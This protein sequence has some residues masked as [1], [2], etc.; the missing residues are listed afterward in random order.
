MTLLS[1]RTV[2]HAG[3]AATLIPAAA[4]AGLDRAG[5]SEDVRVL[6]AA[7]EAMHPGLYSHAT[8]RQVAARFERLQAE[9]AGAGDLGGW[10]VALSRFTAAVRCGHTYPNPYNQSDAAAEALFGGRRCLPFLARWLDGRLVVTGD[11]TASGLFRPGDEVLS[12]GGI[13]TERWRARMLPLMRAD[14]GNDAKRLNNLELRG[15]DRFEAFDVYAS[16][17]QPTLRDEAVVEVRGRDGRRR[18]FSAPLLSRETKLARTAV[19]AAPDAA[20]WTLA[21]R[22]GGVAVLTMPTWAFYDGKW[23]WAAWLHSA[24]DGLVGARARG[25]ILDLRGNEGGR[26]VGD[27]ILSRLIAEP[28]QGGELTRHTRYRRAP[29]ALAPYLDTWDRSFLDWGERAVGPDTQGR[30]A[31]ADA[32]DGAIAPAG[33]R[34]EGRV[35]ALVDASNSSA[36]FQFARA[37]QASGRVTLVGGTTGGNRQGL[38]GGAYFFLRLPG[39]G[40]EVDL[41]LIGYRPRTPQADAAVEPDVRVADTAADIALGRDR[42]LET[43]LRLAAA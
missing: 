40:L 29:P 41:P 26:D 2:L 14:G 39:S 18:R 22:A 33:R 27:V 21:Q 15:R 3:L 5:W 8:P 32:D 10:F 36:T 6:R 9:A 7:Y 35:L 30:Y 25:L 16:L 31:L 12:V 43:A 19:A 37:A 17:L 38:N 1:R 4:R 24:F 23:D 34:F 42:V 13:S 28:L 11:L 20:P